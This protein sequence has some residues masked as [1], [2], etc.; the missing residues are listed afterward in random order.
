MK[1]QGLTLLFGC[2]ALGAGPDAR[3]AAVDTVVHE[4]VVA[5]LVVP[6]GTVKVMGNTTRLPAGCRADAGQVDRP[7]S[8]S[9]SVTVKLRGH[10]RRGE[11]CEGWARVVVAVSAPVLVT[12]RVVRAGEALDEATTVQWREIGPGFKPAPSRAGGVAARTLMAGQALDVNAVRAERP[13]SGG[14]VRVRVRAGAL[15]VEQMGRLI[16]CGTGR[17][18]AVLP[19]GKHVEG[20][21]EEDTL[22]VVAP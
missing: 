19:S 13:A 15:T 11:A 22:V 17:A 6:E 8:A 20:V 3:A 16:S 10:T 9:G 12:T 1:R 4:A 21:L 5:A 2:A 18:C 14:A 7:L